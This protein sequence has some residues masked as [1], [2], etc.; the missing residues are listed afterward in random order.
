[1]GKI[2]LLCQIIDILKPH[3]KLDTFFVVQKKAS[4]KF[5]SMR[6]IKSQLGKSAKLSLYHSLMECHVRNNIISWCHG[7]TTLKNSIQIS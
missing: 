7:N 3:K 1:M 6:K 2:Q 5:R 4:Q